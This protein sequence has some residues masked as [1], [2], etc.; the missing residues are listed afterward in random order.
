MVKHLDFILNGNRTYRQ[1]LSGV[2][3]TKIHILKIFLIH[4]REWVVKEK[5]QKAEG[6]RKPVRKLLEQTR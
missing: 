1:V 5:Q 2:N 4:C 3:N 6:T